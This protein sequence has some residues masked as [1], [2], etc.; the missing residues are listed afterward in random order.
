MRAGEVAE[1]AAHRF[2]HPRVEV[3]RVDQLHPGVGLDQGA[4]SPA[5][6]LETGAEVLPPVAGDEHEL[7]VR[8]E[9]GEPRGH[10][11]L[12]AGVR[13]QPPDHGEQGV[14][15][16]IAGDQ[17]A[18]R[19]HPLGKQVVAG[20]AGGREVKAGQHA[21]QTAV[22]LL[23][24]G[25]L[26]V[27]GAQPGLDVTEGNLVVEGGQAGGHGGGGVAVDEH[28]VRH[29]A[30]EYRFEA[31]QH[32]AGG[33]GQA[34]A[35]PHDVQVEVRADPEQGKHLVEHVTVLAGDAHPAVKVCRKPGQLA[36]HRRHLD[37]LRPGAEYGQHPP[38]GPLLVLTGPKD[39]HSAA[40]SIDDLS[41]GAASGVEQQPPDLEAAMITAIP[42]STCN[43]TAWWRPQTARQGQGRSS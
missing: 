11:P 41:T 35:G 4:Q 30:G 40:R 3:H 9:K 18:V 42:T 14:D 43:G 22:H 8:I 5:N 29:E 25:G 39:T 28:Q 2:L 13:A 6:P 19:G 23:G 38:H 16:G 20:A 27:A 7:F 31:A 26:Q 37:R 34:L 21:G 10:L 33:V 17:D 24:K 1:Q 32:A 12:Q 15:H 36:D